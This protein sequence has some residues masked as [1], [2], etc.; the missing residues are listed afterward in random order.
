[1]REKDTQKLVPFSLSQYTVVSEFT[2]SVN[3]VFMKVAVL[4]YSCEIE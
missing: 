1:M 3:S 4:L 2:G